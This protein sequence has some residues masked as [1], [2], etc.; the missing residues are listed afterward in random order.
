MSTFNTN[1]NIPGRQAGGA[2]KPCGSLWPNGEFSFGYQPA[3]GAERLETP[4]EYARKWDTPIGLAQTSNSHKVKDPGKARRGTKGLTSYGKKMLRN[5]VWRMQRLYGKRRLSFVTLTLPDLTYEEH[6]YVASRWAE[7][8][9]I[10]YQ[11]LG[12]RLAAAGLPRTYAGCTE[13]QPNRSQQEEVPALH[14]HFVVVGRK[15]NHV[16]W[17][18][19]PRTFR[20]IWATVVG[21]YVSPGK[22]W[23]ACENVA[24]VRQDASRYMAKYLSKG[25]S[26]DVPPRSDETGWGLPT[27]WY[28]VS[29]G[30]KRWVSENTRK[31]AGLMEYLESAAIIGFS[32]EAF[33]YLS[34]G[35]LE[36]C[37]GPGPHFCVGRLRG[38][39]MREILEFWNYQVFGPP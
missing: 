26:M 32:P 8:L 6:W 11:K 23:R 19:H 7:I 29:L 24:A 35:T 18:L 10:F 39:F 20:R 38:D 27:A 1:I 3:G 34:W 30:L 4:S 16:S 28:N 2:V 36:K 25:C 13:L 37:P 31:H 12:R 22:N 14:I 21:R 5:S 17:A 33:H 9:R 15:S